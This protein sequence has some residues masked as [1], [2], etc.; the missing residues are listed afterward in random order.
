[1]ARE[2]M[3]HEGMRR[4]QHARETQRIADRLEQ[5]TVHT[6]FTDEDRRFIERCPMLFIATADANGRPDC[7]YKGGLPGFVRVLDRNVLAFPDY[8]GNGMY[9]SWG[10]TLVNPH[11]G[12]LFLDFEHPKRIRVNGRARVSP[13]DPLRGEYPGSVFII[14]VTAESIFPNCPRYIH[15]MQLVEHSVYVP[16]PDHAPPIPAWKSSEAFR[17]ALPARD[18]PGHDGEDSTAGPT[19]P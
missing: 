7:S 10:N 1:M 18:R 6:A 4:L 5:V 13:D 3:Y 17:D 14:R 16:R 11:V 15:T 9:R 2:P 19:K 8:D 12:L